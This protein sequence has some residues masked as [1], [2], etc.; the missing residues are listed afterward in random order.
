M[1]K[2]LSFISMKFFLAYFNNQLFLFSVQIEK[3]INLATRK[4][5]Y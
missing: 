1:Q 3:N 4:D 5:I 2:K